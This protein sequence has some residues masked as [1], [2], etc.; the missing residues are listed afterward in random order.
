[1]PFYFFIWTDENIE[2]LQQHDVSQDEFEAVV[3]KPESQGV[4]KSSKLPYAVARIHGRRIF[5][6]YER[7]SKDTLHPVTAYEIEG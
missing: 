1:M 3:S 7:L 4:S 5:C 2:H 6:V